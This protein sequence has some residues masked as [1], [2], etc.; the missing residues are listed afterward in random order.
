MRLAA[1]LVGGL[2]LLALAA[3]YA[4]R[5][6]QGRGPRV[7]AGTPPAVASLLDGACADC[8]SD[9]TRWPWYSGVPPTSW[10]VSNHVRQGKRYVNFSHFDERSEKDRQDMLRAIAREVESGKMPLR[11]YTLLHPHARLSP[12]ERA[13]IV[14][15]ARANAD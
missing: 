5:P 11:S 4:G 14:T 10:L 6:P 9:N 3:G 15:W 7:P 2:I 12:S 8:H 1:S 13:A